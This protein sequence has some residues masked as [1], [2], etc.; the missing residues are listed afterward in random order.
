MR[1]RTVSISSAG[2]SFSVTGWKVGWV[3]APAA[4]IRAVQT[5]KQFTTFTVGGPFQLAVAHALDHE[6]DWV[7]KQRASL[8]EKRDRLSAG[9]SAAGFGVSETA[10]TYFVQADVRPLGFEDGMA[11]AKALPEKAGV[12][13]IP[14]EVFYDDAEAGRPYV[15]FAFCKQDDVIDEAVRRLSTL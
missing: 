3:C 5:V 15:R 1:G 4:L 2:K 9:L 11:F 7:T 10:G 12:V 8:Q 13:A 6:L 14:S